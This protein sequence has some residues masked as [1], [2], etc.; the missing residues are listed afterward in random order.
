MTHSFP[1]RRSSDLRLDGPELVRGLVIGEAG[2]ELVIEAC[3]QIDGRALAE[4]TLRCDL[5]QVLGELLDPL[6]DAGLALLPAD[7][8]QLVELDRV[9]TEAVAREDLE[10]L[11]RN[12]Q[13]VAA[14]ITELQAV[15]RG[16]AAPEGHGPIQHEERGVGK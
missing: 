7:A 2:G 5:D 10:I 3:G 4:L 11:D 14:M 15:L 8:A 1:T 16:D 12:E 9:L 6:L 13:L